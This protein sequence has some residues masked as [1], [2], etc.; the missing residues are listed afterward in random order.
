MSYLCI[1]L[2]SL[3]LDPEPLN[4]AQEQVNAWYT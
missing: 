1:C 4:I 2:E 3:L